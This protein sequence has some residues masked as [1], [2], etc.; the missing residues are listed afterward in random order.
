MIC[1]TFFHLPLEDLVGDLDNTVVV[2]LLFLSAK[3]RRGQRGSSGSCL[4]WDQKHI[5]G[6]EGGSW[7]KLWAAE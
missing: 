2:G 4:V 7:H 1:P 3:E 6:V 5:P